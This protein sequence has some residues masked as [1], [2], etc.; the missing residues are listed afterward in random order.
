MR[1]LFIVDAFFPYGVAISSRVRSFCSLFVSMGFNVHVIA[2][3]TYE[4]GIMPGQIKEFENYTYEI[5]SKKNRGTFSTFCGD[6]SLIR[7]VRHDLEIHST[8]FILS[9]ACFPYFSTLIKTAKKYNIPYYVEQCEWHDVSSYKFGRFDLRYIRANQLR[10]G[11]YKKANGII[12]ISRLLDEHYKSIGVPSI[13][14]P[15]ILNVRGKSLPNRRENGERISLVYTG[16]PGLSKEFLCPVIECLARNDRLKKRIV[17]HIFGPK[18]KSVL[19]NIG[20]NES[21]LKAAGD[22]VIIHGKVPQ[23]EIPGILLNADYQLFLRPNRKSSNAGFP[24]KLGE[25]MAVGT[26]V[27]ANDTGDISLY[28]KDGINGFLLDRNTVDE[29]EMVFERLLSIDKN[30]YLKMRK[31]ARETAENAFDY[32]S[33]MEEVKDFLNL[34][35]TGKRQ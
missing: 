6:V 31:C 8:N 17:F 1:L 27:I 19:D 4:Q 5:V 3:N 7:A 32:R 26:P 9:T 10:N 16:N 13:R 22:S 28:L 20:G 18:E 2:L 12:S 23:D 21:L 14:I 29:V 30:E 33:Y 35:K 24:T 34:T 25:S 11:G 15:T